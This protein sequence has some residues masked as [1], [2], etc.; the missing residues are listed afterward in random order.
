MELPQVKGWK[1]Q[2]QGAAA[3]VCSAPHQPPPDPA[4]LT[5]QL[6]HFLCSHLL[7]DFSHNIFIPHVTILPGWHWPSPHLAPTPLIPQASS[8]PN[9]SCK[10]GVDV[11][12]VLSP[13]RQAWD[14]FG[15]GSLLPNRCV[16]TEEELLC[17]SFRKQSMRATRSSCTKIQTST[18]RALGA[19]RISSSAARFLKHI[20][21][22]RREAVGKGFK[23]QVPAGIIIPEK[24]FH[25]TASN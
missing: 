13:P 18:P 23:A 11:L 17:S 2:S 6:S 15:S 16:A 20:P 8:L 4:Q 21:E 9:R 1:S 19:G 14:G 24:K 7:W 10:E 25:Q 3:P 12:H 5:P 22:E